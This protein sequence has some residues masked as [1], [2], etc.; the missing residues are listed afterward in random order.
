MREQ[1]YSRSQVEPPWLET[2]RVGTKPLARASGRTEKKKSDMIPGEEKTMAQEKTHKICLLVRVPL[3]I[4]SLCLRFEMMV[5]PV[6]GLWS[7][8]VSV[9]SSSLG[10]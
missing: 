5:S 1:S 8:T 6:G 7:A 3:L 4:V 2:A 10:I 9:K